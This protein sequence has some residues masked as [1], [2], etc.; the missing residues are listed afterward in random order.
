MNFASNSTA[1]E[2]TVATIE[3]GGGRAIAYGA[4]VSQEDQV[5]EMFAKVAAALGP[6]SILVN[7]AGITRDNLCSG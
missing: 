5:E 4:D 1:A 7:N 3:S 2:E 6:V